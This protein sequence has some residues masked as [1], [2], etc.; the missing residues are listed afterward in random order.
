VYFLFLHSIHIHTP[1]FVV[2]LCFYAISY[3]LYLHHIL[4]SISSFLCLHTYIT[5]NTH[6]FTRARTR[7]HTHTHTQIHVDIRYLLFYNGDVCTRLYVLA[8]SETEIG[9]NHL[10]LV[11]AHLLAM[12]LSK[13]VY[14]FSLRP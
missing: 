14:R 11:P 8:R 9:N 1:H 4:S 3:R 5:T 12:S 7:T 13:D 10:D 2:R 6:T